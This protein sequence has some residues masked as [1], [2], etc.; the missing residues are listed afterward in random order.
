MITILFISFTHEYLR[1]YS[2]TGHVN[3]YVSCV[4]WFMLLPYAK[5]MSSMSAVVKSDGAFC[6]R[7]WDKALSSGTDLRLW[8]AKDT[9]TLR[10]SSA[11]KLS[12]SSKAC[13]DRRRE[14]K[15][16]KQSF[17]LSSYNLIVQRNFEV[18]HK[19]DQSR[20]VQHLVFMFGSS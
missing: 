3:T 10:I 20:N 18:R 7:W 11:V 19:A 15:K 12:E 9:Q 2:N 14:C 17:Y 5:A 8:A 4:L 6:R 16:R 1:L 13:K